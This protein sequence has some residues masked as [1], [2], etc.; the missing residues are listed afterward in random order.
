MS[1]LRRAFAVVIGAVLLFTDL[2]GGAA[3]AAIVD[4]PPTPQADCGPGSRP[5]P[6]LQGRMTA[7][8]LAA[9]DKGFWCNTKVV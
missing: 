3:H 4:P 7:A 9:G 1:R 2:Y 6:G 8:Q 5:E